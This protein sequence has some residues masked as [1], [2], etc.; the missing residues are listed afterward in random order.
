[1]RAFSGPLTPYSTRG[2][3]NVRSELVDGVAC[4]PLRL[5]PYQQEYDGRGGRGTVA[6]PEVRQ[7]PA[8]RILGEDGPAMC[9]PPR[10]WH[11]L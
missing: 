1:M 8:E 2:Y 4:H 9:R 6:L 3:K 7:F 10:R 5:T 11:T